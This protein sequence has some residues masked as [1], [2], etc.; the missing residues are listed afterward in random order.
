M[1]GSTEFER[2]GHGEQLLIGE[3]PGR[4]RPVLAVRSGPAVRCL[5]SFRDDDAA[6]D[7][8]AVI[9]ALCNARPEGGGS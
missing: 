6:R 4:K 7:A 3:L 8:I 5:A 2:I 9:K 1:R